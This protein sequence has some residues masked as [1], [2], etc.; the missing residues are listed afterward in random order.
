ML[1]LLAALTLLL[2]ASDHWTTYLCLRHPVMGHNV[3]EANPLAR[4]LF[5]SVGLVEGLMID[6]ALTVAALLFLLQ[7][8]RLPHLLKVGFLA[9]VIAGTGYAVV[10]NL[11][12]LD[13]IGLAASGRASI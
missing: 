9:V 5:D 3:I 8:R 6:S 12:I 4:W 11:G 7:T 1:R 13:Q 10:N 2:S